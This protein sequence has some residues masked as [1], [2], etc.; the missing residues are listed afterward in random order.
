MLLETRR[1]E[2][3]KLWWKELRYYIALAAGVACGVDGTQV[4]DTVI[5]EEGDKMGWRWSRLNGTNLVVLAASLLGEKEFKSMNIV[6]G[7][8]IRLNLRTLKKSHPSS[9]FRGGFVAHKLTCMADLMNSDEDVSS[10]TITEYFYYCR[11][12]SICNKRGDDRK[13]YLRLLH[14]L[15]TWVTQGYRPH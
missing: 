4:K 3:N 13:G 6:S 2:V 9:S 11:L 5:L 1:G 15:A 10:L 7:S 8:E 12:K 14:T